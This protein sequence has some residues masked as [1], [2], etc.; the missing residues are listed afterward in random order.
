M[1]KLLQFIAE[2]GWL[3]NHRYIYIV[4]F[5][6]FAS[7]PNLWQCWVTYESTGSEIKRG[8]CPRMSA[9]L[10]LCGASWARACF[11]LC[12]FLP[13]IYPLPTPR[14]GHTQLITGS[15]KQNTKQWLTLAFTLNKTNGVD[16]YWLILIFMRNCAQVPNKILDRGPL[17]GLNGWF[18]LCK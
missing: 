13:S 14:R 8:L 2:L 10:C 9:E 15:Q 11:C 5:S 4:L 1:T 7:A 18:C 16:L 17:S 3:I 12:N 6:L